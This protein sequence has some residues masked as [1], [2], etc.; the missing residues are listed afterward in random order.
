MGNVWNTAREK[1]ANTRTARAS[2]VWKLLLN[3]KMNIVFGE[4]MQSNVM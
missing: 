1:R 4:Q 3:K 2:Q